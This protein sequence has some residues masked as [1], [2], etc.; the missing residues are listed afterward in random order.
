M[1][2]DELTQSLRRE[3]AP[4]RDEL[5]ALRRALDAMQPQVAG[6]P[7]IHRAL[8]TLRQ[9]SRQIKVAVND[10]AAVQ[11]TTGEVEALH[12]DVNKTMTKQ[13]E[14]EARLSVLERL[15]RELTERR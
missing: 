5:A 2:E 13:D 6:I 7:L 10:L 3:L 15:M 1:T 11:M 4:L 12:A 9:E 8:E 14:L